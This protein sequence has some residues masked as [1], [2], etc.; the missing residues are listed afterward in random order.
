MTCGATSGNMPPAELNRV[1]YQQL[2]VIGSTGS[3][4]TEFEAL[5]RL[6]EASGVRPH[7][8]SVVALDDVR[9]GFQKLI[10]GDVRGKVVVRT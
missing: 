3:T 7:L 2:S 8:D 1:F 4:R 10:D 6:L 5:L 9:S